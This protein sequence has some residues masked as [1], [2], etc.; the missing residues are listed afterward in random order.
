MTEDH[1]EDW[2]IVAHGEDEAAR[3]HEDAEGYD[4]GDAT[5]EMIMKI[6]E[7]V[8]AELGWPSDE[9]LKACGAEIVVDGAKAEL[10]HGKKWD[11]D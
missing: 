3:F 7:D 9:V 6:P 10:V 8:A 1:D 2:F 4:P 11:V 5:V